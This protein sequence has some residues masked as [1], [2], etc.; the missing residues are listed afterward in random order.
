MEWQLK[1]V[2]FYDAA[3]DRECMRLEA[4]GGGRRFSVSPTREGSKLAA[5]LKHLAEQIEGAEAAAKTT[6]KGKLGED[7]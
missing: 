6:P 2:E 1:L 3:E 7:D 5:A 4:V